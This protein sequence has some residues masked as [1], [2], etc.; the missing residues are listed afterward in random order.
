M[1]SSSNEPVSALRLAALCIGTAIA[2]SLPGCAST[3]DARAALRV[4][5]TAG[6]LET[7]YGGQPW[8]AFACD[9]GRSVALVSAPGSSAAPFSFVVRPSEHGVRV[10]GEGTGDR[11]ATAAA[12]AELMAL[13]DA[14]LLRLYERALLEADPGGG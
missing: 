8:L 3:V 5:C 6:P 9:D 14:A 12:F 1:C 11:G 7:N 13:D 4:S 10:Q 2:L